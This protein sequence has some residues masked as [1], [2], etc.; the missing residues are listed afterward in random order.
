MIA[1]G[2]PYVDTSFEGN[3]ALYWEGI[4]AGDAARADMAAKVKEDIT[5]N[6]IEWERWPVKF[7]DAT[8]FDGPSTFEDP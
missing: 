4:G 5:N 7:P 3:N 8:M 2:T 1:A 6:V